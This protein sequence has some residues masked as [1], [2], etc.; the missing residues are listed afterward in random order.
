MLLQLMV[1]FTVVVPLTRHHFFQTPTVPASPPHMM[2]F[3]CLI[4]PSLAFA[5]A[6]CNSDKQLCI[7]M[8]GF[9]AVFLHRCKYCSVGLLFPSSP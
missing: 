1:N 9:N 5:I 8:K 7:A 4:A 2:K 6:T 3:V